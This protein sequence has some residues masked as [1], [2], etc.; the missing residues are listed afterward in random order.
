MYVWS[1]PASGTFYQETV[2]SSHV[3][4]YETKLLPNCTLV[5]ISDLGR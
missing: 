3:G 2:T 1:L 4:K 5:A